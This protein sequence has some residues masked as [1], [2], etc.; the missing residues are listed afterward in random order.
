MIRVDIRTALLETGGMAIYFVGR[1]FFVC[2]I[3]FFEGNFVGVLYQFR[4]GLDCCFQHLLQFAV[5]Y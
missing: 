3:I 2:K 5:Y 1:N 4:L